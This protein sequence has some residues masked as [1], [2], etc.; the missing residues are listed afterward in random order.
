MEANITAVTSR[1]NGNVQLGNSVVSYSDSASI[2]ASVGA[3]GAHIIALRSSFLAVSTCHFP[4][5]PELFLD[6]S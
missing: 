3:Q 2:A 6:F 5:P 1:M 4:I